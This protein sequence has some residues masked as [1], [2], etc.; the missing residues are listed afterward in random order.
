MHIDTQNLTIAEEALFKA[1]SAPEFPCVGAKSAM[2]RG[3][4]KVL[5]CRS[6]ASGWDDLIIHRELM[7]W[8][9]DYRAEPGGLRSL[10][11][12]FDGPADLDEAQFEVLMW[13][14]IQSFADKD[15]WLGQPH[16]HRVSTDPSDRISRSALAA[17]PSSLSASTHKPRVRRGGLPGP[18]WCSTFMISSNACAAKAAMKRCASAS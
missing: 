5:T 16:D 8:A 7:D 3:T 15:A 10:A 13:E 4:L 1:I 11:V 6:L 18:R 17:R 12:S 14:R 9:A 2:A